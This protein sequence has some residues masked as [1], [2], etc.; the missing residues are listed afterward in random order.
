M[1]LPAS[2][3]LPFPKQEKVRSADCQEA[4]SMIP[5]FIADTLSERELDRF[6]MHVRSCRHCHAELETNFMVEKTVTL[7]NEE[8]PEDVSFDLTPL[9]EL[10]LAERDA[11]LRRVRRITKLRRFVAA[12]T[13]AL[14][15][16]F[17]LDLTGVFQIT[18]FF[19]N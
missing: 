11:G 5:G 6:L 10:E 9:L 3:R 2:L 17:L 7:L 1:L 8:L 4:A 12:A 16:F 15:L 19:S 13:A 18:V 14:I